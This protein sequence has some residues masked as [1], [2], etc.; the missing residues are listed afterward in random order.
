MNRLLRIGIYVLAAG[1]GS[2]AL[3]YPF[4]SPELQKPAS[5]TMA[6]SG[7]APLMYTL[8][9]GLCVMVILFE[10]QS[11]AVDTKLIALLGTLI[12]INSILSFIEVAVPGP[13]G[14]S[15]IFFLIILV[16]YVFG[17]PL[18]FV[19]GAL[20]LFTSAIITGG[21]GAWLPCQMFVAGWVGMSA[22]A[23]RVLARV[24]RSYN[25]P[26]EIVLL[27]V[28]GFFWG[29]L[30]GAAM[31]LWSWPYMTG[32]ADQ[33][34]SSGIGLT[35]T[36]QRYGLYYLVTSLVWDASSAVGNLILILVAGSATLRVLRRFQE[37][38]SFS[39]DPSFS[40]PEWDQR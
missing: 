1:L 27:A 21:V 22:P 23:V 20:T 2:I 36:L 39:Y 35:A 34:W 18:G 19:M 16:G 8:L 10:V 28:F 11:Q 31:N 38:F 29:F 33:Y 9:L 26:G 17:A 5:I 32:P 37:R 25:Q 15:P 40:L 12:A 30:Y 13:G 14:F 4:F 3:L 6:R 7:E 24:F